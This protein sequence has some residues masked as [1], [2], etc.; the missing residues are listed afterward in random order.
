VEK[1]ITDFATVF[2]I[3]GFEQTLVNSER[4]GWHLAVHGVVESRT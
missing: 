3:L 2:V 1:R 4:G